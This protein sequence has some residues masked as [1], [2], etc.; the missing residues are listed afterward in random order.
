MNSFCFQLLQR[1]VSPK[2]N[3]PF[4]LSILPDSAGI[5]GDVRDVICL[6]KQDGR[7]IGFSCKHNRYAVKHSRLSDTIDF[8]KQWVAVPCSKEYFDTIVPLFS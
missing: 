2:N 5:K 3:E 6:R 4:D 1:L 8:G 7:V